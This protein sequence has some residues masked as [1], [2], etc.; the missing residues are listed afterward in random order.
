M[1]CSG[2]E[3][4][5]E[6]NDELIHADGSSD[7]AILCRQGSE[8]GLEAILLRC[9]NPLGHGVIRSLRLRGGPRLGIGTGKGGP[10]QL[11]LAP[12]R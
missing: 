11:A 6:S 7:S 2:G 5:G 4:R 10:E 8:G 12:R 1:H 3:G 9:S